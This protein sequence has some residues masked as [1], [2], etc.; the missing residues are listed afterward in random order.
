MS[1][2]DIVLI[3]F[4]ALSVICNAYLIARVVI[5]RGNCNI[6]KSKLDAI[7]ENL[8]SHAIDNGNQGGII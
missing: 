6:F 7:L 8:K 2:I 3:C 4:L 5:L 1:S